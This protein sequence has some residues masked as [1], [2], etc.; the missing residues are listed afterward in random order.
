MHRRIGLHALRRSLG[1]LLAEIHDHDAI[2]E[3]HDEVHVVLDQQHAHAFG[4]QLAQQRR[5]TL[6]LR[7]PQVRRPVRP[8][9]ADAGAGRGRGRSPRRAAGP[10]ADRRPACRARRQARPPS[11][12]RA[13]RRAAALSSARSSRSIA[14]NMPAR[15]DR[16]APSATF[17]STLRRR[18]QR[19]HAG[20]CA[21]RPAPRCDA[22][23]D[24]AQRAHRTGGWCRH[25][26]RS[27]PL[28]TLNSVVLPAPF[29]PISATISLACTAKLTV[30]VGGETAEV[31][32]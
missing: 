31:A 5:E 11:L 15:P 27:T 26:A 19:A 6:L 29:G 13:P 3:A 18:Q 7:Q 16:C 32:R 8:A 17:S 28:I 9:A 25:S 23:A 2:G 10:T 24:A 20:R 21:R 30:A 12:T 14:R 1:D 22:A 4:A